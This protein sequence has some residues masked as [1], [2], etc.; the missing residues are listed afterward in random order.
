MRGRGNENS[1]SV[2]GLE[3]KG[4]WE[5]WAQLGHNCLFS[6]LA[7]WPAA[8]W[9]IKSFYWLPPSVK[10]QRC[11]SIQPPS[12]GQMKVDVAQGLGRLSNYEN[13]FGL[14][15]CFSAAD[16]SQMVHQIV[17]LHCIENIGSPCGKTFWKTFK[18]KYPWKHGLNPWRFA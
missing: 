2:L 7:G 16:F 11:N 10:G 4:S 5:M 9:S 8:N 14:R 1:R 17:E 18:I 13:V 6:H 3:K 15:N 12:P